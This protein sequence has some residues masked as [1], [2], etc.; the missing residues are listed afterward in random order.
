MKRELGVFAA[1]MLGL[2]SILGTGVFVSIGIG[3]DIAGSSVILAVACAAV[4][5]MCN[6]ISSAQ[7]AANHPV[8]GGTY[9][10]GH[11]WLNPTLGFIAGWMFICAKSASA[12]TAALGLAAYALHHWNSDLT[13]LIPIAI[14]AITTLTAIAMTGIKRSSRVNTIIVSITIIALTAFVLTGFRSTSIF[15]SQH[16]DD[17]PSL[18]IDKPGRFFE[19]IALMFVAYTGYGRI[20]TL[21]EEVK[22][23]R[24]TIPRAI[25]TTLLVSLT[26]YFLVALVAVGMVGASTFGRLAN[27][28]IAPLHKLSSKLDSN[29][30]SWIIVVGAVTAMLGVLLN[31]V[32]GLSRVLLAMGRRGDVPTVLGTIHQASG[33][34]RFAT[35]TVGVIIAA[36]VFIGDVKL[37]WTFSAFTVLI[38]YALTNLCAIRLSDE[39]R[40]YPTWISYAGFI[41]CLFLT[42]WI[43]RSVWIAGML[44]LGVGWIWHRIAQ[45]TN[46]DSK[47]K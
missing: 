35:I 4:L 2:G 11:R 10:Y 37:T 38:Y 23:P 17:L 28:E 1:M 12:A 19:C 45:S 3:A 9:E 40:L 14:A 22:Q 24:R 41:G 43:D 32:L 26:L 25:V 31:L 27:T 7:L 33:I 29:T 8:S 34:P 15:G 18:I 44:I 39:Q 42:Y 47:I 46:N 21:G 13:Y 6:G 30:I 20:A 5:A 16:F 36:L